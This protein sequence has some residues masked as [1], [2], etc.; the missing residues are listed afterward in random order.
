M[1]IIIIFLINGFILSGVLNELIKKI[2]RLRYMTP[3]IEKVKPVG[4]NK[5]SNRSETSPVV[6]PPIGRAFAK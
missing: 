2:K 6:S 5:L 3:Q 4:V 1:N